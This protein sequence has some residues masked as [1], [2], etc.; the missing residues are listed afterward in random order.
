MPVETSFP[1]VLPYSRNA[2]PSLVATFERP[3]DVCKLLGAR[4]YQQGTGRFTQRDPISAYTSNRYLYANNNP[5]FLID[6]E[7]L[8][9]WGTDGPITFQEYRWNIVQALTR[10]KQLSNNPNSYCMKAFQQKCCRKDSVHATASNATA[11]IAAVAGAVTSAS[12]D[13]LSALAYNLSLVS[14]NHLE[15]SQDPGVQA[16]LAQHPNTLTGVSVPN[17]FQIWIIESKMKDPRAFFETFVHELA[18]TCGITSESRCSE[19][20]RICIKEY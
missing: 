13:H 12:S 20:E 1:E 9:S 8:W 16:Q 14:I 5:V 18:H 3:R 7:G 6:P 15:S 19:I 17:G 10:L 4:F 2:S 11:N